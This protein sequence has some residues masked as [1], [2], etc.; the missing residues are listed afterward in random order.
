MALTRSCTYLTHL[1]VVVDNVAD[2]LAKVNNS[3]R[4]TSQFRLERSKCETIS[5]VS[6]FYD[7]L[8]QVLL[9]KD[10]P[11][12][13]IDTTPQ[14]TTVPVN[15]Q[16]SSTEISTGTASTFD[17]KSKHEYHTK[18]ATNDSFAP[19]LTPLKINWNDSPG[20]VMIIAVSFIRTPPP[21]VAAAERELTIQVRNKK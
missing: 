4:L 13:S 21:P 19:R 6:K 5:A 15:P 9:S 12:A 10:V 18:A 1:T 16:Y 2:G 17:L 14:Q 7:S 3:N 8:S 20:I 11:P